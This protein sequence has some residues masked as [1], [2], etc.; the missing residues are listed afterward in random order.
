MILEKYQD[1]KSEF[2]KDEKCSSDLQALQELHSFLTEDEKV[3]KLMEQDKS[4][5]LS[6]EFMEDYYGD[7]LKEIFGNYLK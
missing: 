7:V 4:K 3:K 1:L 2:E 5:P 6:N